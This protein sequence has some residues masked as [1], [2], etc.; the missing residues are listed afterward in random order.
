MQG[1]AVMD[2]I[3]SNNINNVNDN[4]DNNESNQ[5]NDNNENIQ[6]NESSNSGNSNS[7][8]ID[9]PDNPVSEPSR[10]Y[11]ESYKRPAPRRNNS[12]LQLILVALIS[13]IFGGG[14]VFLAFQFLAPS[15]QPSINQFFG[16]SVLTGNTNGSIGEKDASG[17]SKKIIIETADSPVAAI[18]EKVGPSIVGIRVT[19]QMQD[20]F[21]GTKEGQGEGSGIIIRA[22]GYIMT[23]NHVVEAAMAA[24]RSNEISNGSKIEVILPNKK[25]KPYIAK[26]IGRD[27]KTDLAVLKI[28]ATG[29]PAVEQGDSDK[30]KVGEL[31]VAIGNPAGLEFM[32]SVTSGIISGLNRKI[33]T[34]DGQ[35]LTLIQTDAAINQGNSGGALV[36]SKGQVI[37]IN[38]IKIGATG[39]EGL[40]FAI[41]INKAKEITKNLIEYKYVKGRPFLGISV[42]PSY[43][44]EMAK[45]YN[46][47]NG[48]LVADVIPVSGAYKS[49][50]QRGDI[51]TK[52]EDTAVTS[53]K[54]L[55]DIKNKYKPGDT[56]SLEAYRD[57]KTMKFEV[58]LTEDKGT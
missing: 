8:N 12:L 24:N 14:I 46:M 11:T 41:P 57:G 39:F 42:D 54:E 5:N 55:E 37:G 1:V 36:N 34:E 58:K 30:L 50:L 38:T 2:D 56:I 16:K 53:F 3:N 23:N 49:G 40:G 33:I 25:D 45:Q 47:P 43:N 26:V 44:E 17:S 35:E 31:A 19:A 28:D 51:I 22:D 10:F 48:L 6:N 32:G 27:P 52:V 21:L 29:L 4:A 7:S 18:S 15:L 20:W 13:S 9:T